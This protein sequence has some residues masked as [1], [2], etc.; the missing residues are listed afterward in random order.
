MA[1]TT[2]LP[3]AP[4]RDPWGS[5]TWEEW[6]RQLRDRATAPLVSVSWSG[7][8]FT[9]STLTD[10][11]DRKHN[12]LTSIQGGTT[13]EYYHL[14]SSEYTELQRDNNVT[15]VTTSTKTLTDA[16]QTVL[17]TFSG[18]L[19]TLPAASTSRIGKI[20]TVIL[21]TKGY[22]VV[23]RSG[24]DTLNINTSET[25]VRLRTKGA[26]VSFKCLTSTSWGIV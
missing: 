7:I 13:G 16:E 1:T 8:D 15:T 4:V 23:Q 20:W 22:T 17:V 2:P 18:C 26:S 9:G 5:Y 10:I 19:V 6:F 3:P 11:T 12:Y 24:S 25:S 21:G 14:T